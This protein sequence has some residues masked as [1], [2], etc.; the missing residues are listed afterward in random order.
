MS[1]LLQIIT[2]SGEQRDIS[3]DSVCENATLDELTEECCTLDDFR[4]NCDNLYERVRA[5]FFLYSIHRFHIPRLVSS[6]SSA[7][8]PFYG[9]QDLL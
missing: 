4:R 2:S 5:L 8:I 9:Y 1:R 7:Q 3:L 6:T